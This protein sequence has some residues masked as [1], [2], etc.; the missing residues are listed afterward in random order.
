MYSNI[1]N[2]PV[3][4]IFFYFFLKFTLETQIVRI[5]GN[6]FRLFEQNKSQYIL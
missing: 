3:L 1:C 2:L 6:W 5:N 4:C